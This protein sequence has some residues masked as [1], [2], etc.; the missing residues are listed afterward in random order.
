MNY[1]LS[2]VVYSFLGWCC[3]TVYC[4]IGAKK[5]INRGFLNGPVCPVYGFGAMAVILMLEPVKNSA[6]LVFSLGMV[7]TS[8]LEYITGYL[9]ETLFHTKW[10]DYSTYRFNIHGRVCLRNSL[11][12]GGLCVVA[13][14]GINPWVQARINAIPFWWQTGLTVAIGLYFVADTVVTVQTILELNGRL[15]QMQKLVQD[16]KER[17]QEYRGA[18]ESRLQEHF[19]RLPTQAEVTSALEAAAQR[20]S[21]HLPDKIELE[22]AWQ[23]AAERLEQRVNE[24]AQ[25]SKLRQ[26]RLLQAFPNMRSTRYQGALEKLK[27]G[28]KKRYQKQ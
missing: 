21:S 2:F 16:V 15:E 13:V 24:L 5:F 4:S 10:W 12:F 26:R 25:N 14:Q 9:L 11:M 28:L 22:A 8:I 23:F 6:L 1:F 3:E 18:L 19:H 20:L 27:E 7:V 17:Q